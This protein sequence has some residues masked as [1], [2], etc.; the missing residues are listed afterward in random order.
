[1][2]SCE[3]LVVGVYALRQI[4]SFAGNSLRN[5][6]DTQRPLERHAW[7]FAT[8]SDGSMVSAEEENI[9]QNSMW[10]PERLGCKLT[11]VSERTVR[12]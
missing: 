5:V 11:I 8:V 4:V 7:P 9:R 12:L 1:M 6:P 10:I 2:Q 3:S